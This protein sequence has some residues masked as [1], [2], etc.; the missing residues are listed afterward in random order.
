MTNLPPLYYLSVFYRR[1]RFFSRW[2][3]QDQLMLNLYSQFVKSG[4]ICF[5]IGAHTGSRV[6]IFL[7]L[8]ATVVAAEPQNSCM[9]VLKGYFGNNPKVNLIHKALG[10]EEGEAEMFISD[11]SP[12]SSLSTTWLE[13]VNKSGRF[14][15][16][17]WD[18]SQVVSVTTL[19]ELTAIFGKPAFIKIDVEGYEYEVI[20]GLS[21]PARTLSLEFTP[22]WLE[23]TINS[24]EH[25]SGLG[26]IQ[27]NY[28][29]GESMKLALKNWVS[30]EELI[31]TLRTVDKKEFGDVYVKFMS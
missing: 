13:A 9:R 7:K 22:E 15:N 2:T 5:D 11:A 14:A 31:S 10:Q 20:R 16:Y 26:E 8:G 4:D 19:D 25:L 28:S 1:K 3:D 27:L 21:R 6:K 18:K 30:P 12:L 29:L 23:S 17:K 24:I